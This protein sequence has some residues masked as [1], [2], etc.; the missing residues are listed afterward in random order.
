[1]TEFLGIDK[2]KLE[3]EYTSL[4]QII[5]LENNLIIFVK[6]IYNKE[7]IDIYNIDTG[8]LLYTI[9]N[10]ATFK[11]SE[12][13]RA[14]VFSKLHP[15]ERHNKYI[16]IHDDGR[17]SIIF[18][19]NELKYLKFQKISDPFKI[20]INSIKLNYSDGAIHE[21]ILFEHEIHVPRNSKIFLLDDSYF[22][23]TYVSPT[24]E[25]C[26]FVFN[27][28]KPEFPKKFEGLFCSNFTILGKRAIVLTGDDKIC[29][30]DIYSEK[31]EIIPYPNL[32]HIRPEN[33]IKFYKNLMLV[34]I[35]L[36]SS[37]EGQYW[38]IGSIIDTFVYRIK[39]MPE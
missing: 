37:S 4:R 5:T 30:Y 12:E 39:D 14:E 35:Y 25:K 34:N 8:K 13:V 38:N 3:G 18:N 19:V 2:F 23:L 29:I 31:M 27:E 16:T 24:L 36:V 32:K 28:M 7:I 15:L 10:V 22:M 21:N 33:A 26:T 9:N 1:M 11:T 6:Y 17:Q 20:L